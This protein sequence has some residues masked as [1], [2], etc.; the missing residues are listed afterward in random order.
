MKFILNILILFLT[1]ILQITLVSRLEIF[2]ISPDFVFILIIFWSVSKSFKETIVLAFFA[3]LFLDI[4]S[5]SAFGANTVSLLL[6]SAVFNFTSINILGKNNLQTFAL[7]GFAGTIIY[8]ILMAFF[9]KLISVIYSLGIILWFKYNFMHFILP[10]AVYNTVL[11]S[12]IF[13]L[14]KY[15]KFNRK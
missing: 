14:M 2:G 4:F 9:I 1:A 5:I 7:F 11:I 6:A 8:G 15:L 3:G 13:V 12:L 10:E